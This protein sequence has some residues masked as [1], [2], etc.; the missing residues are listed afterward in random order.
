MKVLLL[1]EFSY[2]YR[3]LQFGLR[4][5]GCQ[6]QLASHGD[7]WKNVPRDIDLGGGDGLSAKFKR[8]IYPLL[9]LKELQGYDVVQLIN[10]FY[11]YHK[12]FPNKFFFESII[13]NNESLYL[14]AA[15]EDAFYWRYGVDTLRYTP[16]ADFLKYDLKKD[17]YYLQSDKS[18]EFNRWLVNRAKG[19]IPIMV[20]YA[21]TQRG[22]ENLEQVI[23]IPMKVNS[24]EYKENKVGRKLVVFHGLNR[25][26]FKGT[27]H[28]EAAF[29]ILEKK[30]PND[31][32]LIIDG[33]MPITQYL[34][35]MGRANIV[36]DQT[37]CYSLGVNGIYAMA[38]GKVVLGGSEPESLRAMG[39][40]ESP[41]I[42][43]TPSA[44]DIVR[45]IEFLIENRHLISQF[46]AESRAFVEHHHDHLKISQRY[47]DVWRR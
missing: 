38:L 32:E 15:G 21:I 25:Y 19:V 2:L 4:E 5:L 46:G 8:K 12:Y 39:V 31:L 33:H 6:V 14:S 42:N 3:N 41:V 34:E 40:E 20:D 44:D 7:G 1:G 29:K 10:P 26:G 9:K 18:L 36:I 30:Y 27:H 28:V 47:L 23:P 35:V 37:T 22:V 45:K 17:S 43:I 11:F 16:F 24:I 13:G